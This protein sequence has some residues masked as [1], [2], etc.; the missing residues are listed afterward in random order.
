MECFYVGHVVIS[1]EVEI[2][3]DNAGKFR[4]NVVLFS[5]SRI[6]FVQVSLCMQYL[7]LDTET[8]VLLNLRQM[9]RFGQKNFWLLALKRRV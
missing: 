4:K 6:K 5:R 3:T 2:E 9:T 1:E 7:S 8:L